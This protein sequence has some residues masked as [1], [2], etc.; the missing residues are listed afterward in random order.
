MYDS[1]GQLEGLELRRAAL[2]AA[3]WTVRQTRVLVAD[4][5]LGTK[6]HWVSPEGQ[7]YNP[8]SY[9][10]RGY[11][12]STAAAA[13]HAPPVELSVDAALQWLLKG[14]TFVL[15]GD[16]VGVDA[17][18]ITT[19]RYACG[20]YID[21]DHEYIAGSNVSLADAICRAYLAY[22]GGAK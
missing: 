20:L 21:A 15:Y 16:M 7:H 5:S 22:K 6:W 17:S 9:F 11:F 10:E 2:E 3:G 12:D 18:T 14:L 4:I 13:S 19:G 8:D 1:N